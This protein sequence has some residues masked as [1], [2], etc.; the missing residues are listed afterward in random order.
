VKEFATKKEKR[1]ALAED[2]HGLCWRY[3]MKS[4]CCLLET[5]VDACSFRRYCNDF[6]ATHAIQLVKG[7]PAVM[8]Q[9]RVRT[10]C[11]PWRGWVC[12][13]RRSLH[14]LPGLFKCA[15]TSQWFPR[16]FAQFYSN[17]Y[18]TCVLVETEEPWAVRFFWFFIS[19]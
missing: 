17:M 8:E 15:G 11:S 9:V 4:N 7:P 18:R 13:I 2:R 3:L 6:P 1:V 10:L 19:Y 14:R 5:L 12:R 16:Q